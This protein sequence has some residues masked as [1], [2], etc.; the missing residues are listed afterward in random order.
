MT[1]TNRLSALLVIPALLF[2]AAVMLM[3]AI[4]HAY[5]DKYTLE[6]GTTG[7]WFNESGSFTTDSDCGLRGSCY[8]QYNVQGN[9][10]SEGVWDFDAAQTYYSDSYP[11]NYSTQEIFIGDRGTTGYAYYL[12]HQWEYAYADDYYIGC[13]VNQYGYNQDWV[14]LCSSSTGTEVIDIE[15]TDGTIESTGWYT[16]SWD[17]ASAIYW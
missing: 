12:V 7:S 8:W 4:S 13:F 6:D 2:V 10:N 1:L 16:V 5:Y 9:G 3:P 14:E 15:L 11:Y 17:A